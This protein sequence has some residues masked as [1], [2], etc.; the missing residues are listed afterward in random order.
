MSTKVPV[1]WWFRRNLKG[2]LFRLE[3]Q[4]GYQNFNLL[5]IAKNQKFVRGLSQN[6]K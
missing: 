3:K 6:S 5:A 4:E 1:F 2:T